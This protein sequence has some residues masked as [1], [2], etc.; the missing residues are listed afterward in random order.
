MTMDEYRIN[1]ALIAYI[2]K[3]IHDAKAEDLS[4]QAEQDET[5]AKIEGAL[6]LAD[7]LIKQNQ[8]QA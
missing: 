1:A 4:K 8:G 7:E 2:R 5:V 6:G 3:E